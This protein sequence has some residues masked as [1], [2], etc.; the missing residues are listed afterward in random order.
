MRSGW[1]TGLGVATSVLGGCG[2]ASPE[3]TS[4]GANDAVQAADAG[5]Q[6][7]GGASGNGSGGQAGGTT[8]GSGNSGGGDGCGGE[9][10]ALTRLPTHV[11]LVVDR[12]SSMLEASDSS[13]MPTAAQRGSCAETNSAPATGIAYRTRWDDMTSAVGEV[14]AGRDQLIELGLTVFPGPGELSATSS[15]AFCSDL[16]PATLVQPALGQADAI[17]AALARAD[18]TPICAGGMTPTRTALETAAYA[19]D[20]VGAQGGVIVL[21]TDGGPNCAASTPSP[22]TCTT[23]SGFCGTLGTIGCLDDVGTVDV[24]EQ[25]AARNIKTYVV[26][27][28]GTEAYGSVLDRMAVAGNTARGQAPKYYAAADVKALTDALGVI[29]EAAVT[30]NFELENTPPDTMNINVFVDDAPLP[31]DAADGFAYN[32]QDNAVELTGEICTRLKKGQISEVRFE[33]GCPPII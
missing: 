19:L 22:C 9:A 3:S 6:G 5:G 30:C 7:G 32:T 20:Q 27:I 18:S 14:V 8:S 4:V 15:E 28:P 10:I 16:P 25:L 23:G 17:N 1:I 33:F 26:G 24:I 31:R 13:S 12:S 2:A 29:T 11:M 21:A